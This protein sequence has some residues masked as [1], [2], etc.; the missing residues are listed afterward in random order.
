VIGSSDDLR[1][2]DVN[3]NY[4]KTA[5]NN[6]FT[7][8][9]TID[10]TTYS[11]DTS[12]LPSGDN[13]AANGDRAV[14][15]LL[16]YADTESVMQQQAFYDEAQRTLAAEDVAG[17]R[18]AMSGLDELQGTADDYTLALIYAGLTTSADIV[19]D[20]D[21]SQAGF[22]AT[23]YGGSS[24]GGTDHWRITSASIYFNDGYDWF[25]NDVQQIPEPSS[26][27]ALVGMGIT[28]LIGYRWRRKK[29]AA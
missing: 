21:N 8:P 22:A 14:A 23:Y 5:D 19:I 11:R 28:G 20:F 18:Y 10:S 26:V 12:N 6:P 4:F 9:A 27:A 7:L 17:I 3:L 2:D 24:I 13:Y 25:F 15:A 16:G 29:R 1:G